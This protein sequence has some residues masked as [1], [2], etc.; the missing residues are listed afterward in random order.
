MKLFTG[1]SAIAADPNKD[2]YESDEL[3]AHGL[4]VI[5]AVTA[6]VGLLDDAEKLVPILQNLGK[7]HFDK[8]IKKEH[9]PVVG[10]ALL[11]TLQAGLGAFEFT[12]DI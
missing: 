8:G 2:L 3:K 7:F 6:A 5:G 10:K 11:K 9:Y 12:D 4:K 1:F